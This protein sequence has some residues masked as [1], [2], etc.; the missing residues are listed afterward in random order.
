[1]PKPPAPPGS[2]S[3]R[4]PAV[5]VQAP[6]EPPAPLRDATEPERHTD[7]QSRDALL[8]RHAETVRENAE[9]RAALAA[10]A[11]RVETAPI[12]ESGPEFSIHARAGSSKWWS[13]VLPLVLGSGGGAATSY[14]LRYAH[15]LEEPPASQAQLGLVTEKVNSLAKSV[16]DQSTYLAGQRSDLAEWQL[17]DSAYMCSQRSVVADGLPCTEIL[18][19]VSVNPDPLAAAKK[20]AQLVIHTRMPALRLFEKKSKE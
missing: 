10:R 5:E 6:S 20:P 4:R 7:V 11:V 12:D 14:G 1:M 16:D 15:Q 9:L 19:R 8:A 3:G 18:A 17:F 13:V 2:Y